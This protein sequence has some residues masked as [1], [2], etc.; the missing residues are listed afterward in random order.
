MVVAPR[1]VAWNT[2]QKKRLWCCN[3]VYLL[4][5]RNNH[6]LL[7]LVLYGENKNTE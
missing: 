2:R 3:R 7:V 4:N 5:Y 1:V 6:L